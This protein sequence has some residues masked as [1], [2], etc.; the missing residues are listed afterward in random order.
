MTTNEEQRKHCRK[1]QKLPMPENCIPC[2]DVFERTKEIIEEAMHFECCPT[3]GSVEIESHFCP[4]C[5]ERIDVPDDAHW[6]AERLKKRY[7]VEP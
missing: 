2:M 5:K 1:C 4:K 7:G 3:C 6:F